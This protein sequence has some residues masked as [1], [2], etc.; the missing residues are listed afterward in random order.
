MIEIIY[1]HKYCKYFEALYTYSLFF[2]IILKELTFLPFDFKVTIFLS[3]VRA[4]FLRNV[5]RI[6]IKKGYTDDIA[7]LNK[8]FLIKCI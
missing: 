6:Q 7:K 2:N 3:E 8:V 1:I 5:G 4:S